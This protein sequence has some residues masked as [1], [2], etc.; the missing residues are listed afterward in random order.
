MKGRVYFPGLHALRFVAACLVIFHH[1]H[2]YKFWMDM[3][4]N[5]GN[6]VID[7]M[8]H[9]A[10]SF[11][12][13]LSGFLITFLLLAENEKKGTISISGFYLRRVLRIWPVYFLIVMLALWV[14]PAL[15]PDQILSITT[16]PYS[17]FTVIALL[18]FI[19][20]VLRIVNPTVVGANQLW[21]VGI[22][23]Q[24]YLIWPLLVKGFIKRVL[25]FLY[26]FVMLK[27]A[28]H[29]LLYGSSEMTGM[30]RP[31][32]LLRLYELFPVEQMAI[33]AIGA[34]FMYY[35]KD[36]MLQLIQSN[37]AFYISLLLIGLLTI[38]GFH[39]LGLSYL[40]AV[41]FT[42]VIINVTTRKAIYSQLE[43]GVFL[44]LG[45]ISYGIYMYHSLVIILVLT[46]LNYFFDGYSVTYNILL[47][48][49]SVGLTLV[50]SHLSYQYFEKPFLRMKNWLSIE[51]LP[52]KINKTKR[53]HT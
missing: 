41:L 10:V 17:T 26:F 20:N 35:Q 47:Y 23:E 36:R 45:D 29:I 4:N 39:F 37:V 11:F 40:E 49:L 12:F 16:L 27:F 30:L 5:W 18:A 33:G 44:K 19:P 15:I 48:T 32:Q 50:L 21:S 13:V 22:E 7:A 42:I 38:T 2:Q 46:G 31:S 43:H 1:I 25:P 51:R 53:A 14:L 28:G 3:P 8:G 6:P 9:K 24:F 52:I 34:S